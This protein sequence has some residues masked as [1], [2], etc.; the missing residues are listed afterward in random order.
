MYSLTR[1]NNLLSF[2]L[3][4]IITNQS[5]IIWFRVNMYMNSYILCIYVYY[6]YILYTI[7]K[8]LWFI[9]FHI[10]TSKQEKYT[11]AE[12]VY[13]YFYNNKKLCCQ[14]IEVLKI[15]FQILIFQTNFLQ[16]YKLNHLIIKKEILRP[17]FQRIVW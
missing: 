2:L 4:C 7:F 11:L 3:L 12:V 6:T 1:T 5:Q 16:I 14:S 9:K 13:K 8:S 10:Q 15:F 17:L